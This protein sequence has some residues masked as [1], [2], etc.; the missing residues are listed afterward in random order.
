MV[1]VIAVFAVIAFAAAGGLFWWRQRVGQEIALMAATPTSKATEV[2]RLAPGTAVEVKG[3]LRCTELLTAELS[4]QACVYFKSLI[5]RETAYYAHDSQGK[6]ERKT[7]T[8]TVQSNTRF[9]PCQV[10]DESGKVAVDLEGADVEGRQVVDRR[11][12]EQ[13]SLGSTVV[14]IALGSNES[15]TLVYTETVLP[16]D[17]PIYV[18]GEVQADHSIGKPEANSKNRIFVVSS[19]SEEQRSKDLRSSMLWMLVGTVVLAAIAVGLTIWAF[20]TGS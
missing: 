10:E 19:K 8:E 3:T 16:Q 15:S 20:K 5:Q 6:R 14:G 17:I 13:Q 2:A 9:A 18:L 11:E 1:W 7:R 4:K 12:A